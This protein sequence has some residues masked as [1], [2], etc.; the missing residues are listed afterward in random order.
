MQALLSPPEG[1]RPGD[2]FP[3]VPGG[4]VAVETELV[5]WKLYPLAP[6]NLT[7]LDASETYRGLWLLP[8]VDL[9]YFQRDGA[10]NHLAGSSSSSG[11][12]CDPG[13]P[14]VRAGDEDY[15]LWMPPVGSYPADAGTPLYYTPIVG[16]GVQPTITAATALGDAVDLQAEMNGL[17]AVCR[18]V[19]SNYNSFDPLTCHPDFTGIV[20]DYPEDYTA[21]PVLGYH[22]DAMAL[23]ATTGLRTAGGLADSRT[24]PDFT[25]NKVQ[26]L[27]ETEV[28]ECFY[29]LLLQCDVDLPETVADFSEAAA[30]TTADLQVAPAVLLGLSIPNREPT[31]NEKEDLLTAAKQWFLLYRLWRRDQSYM[32]FPGIVPVIP[33]GH[34]QLI[35]WDFQ[36][37][38]FRTTYVAVDGVEG[39]SAES[40]KYAAK[41]LPFYAR[42]DGEG[43]VSDGLHGVYAYTELLDNN[44]SLAVGA[45]SRKGYVTGV[46]GS[47]ATIN[48]ARDEYGKVA[49]PVGLTVWLKPGKCYL[50][51]MTGL[52]FDHYLFTTSDLVQIIRRKL[53]NGQSVL[54][55]GDPTKFR[56]IIRRYDPVTNALVSSKEAWSIYLS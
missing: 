1:E 40:R 8:L 53:V 50:D 11:A 46:G 17:R 38:N 54:K 51:I 10:L 30:P 41:R 56:V 12:A 24:L 6:V 48:P 2:Q 28:A 26:F 15:P 31:A 42:I 7:T 3:T 20:A 19:R 25:A 9:R 55:P 14:T 44:G 52:C 13:F 43:S 34:A 35:R 47:Y 18:D 49:V 27:F 22:Q 29:S 16:N 23:I 36:S 37:D 4:P 45:N 32:R 5:A 39:T 33:N 21:S